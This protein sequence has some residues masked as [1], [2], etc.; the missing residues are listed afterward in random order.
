MGVGRG[1]ARAGAGVVLE[2]GAAASSI[3]LCLVLTVWLYASDN[4]I[5]KYVQLTEILEE[6]SDRRY[7]RCL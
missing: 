3:G 1:D 4:Q 6:S 5:A 7:Q 2:R